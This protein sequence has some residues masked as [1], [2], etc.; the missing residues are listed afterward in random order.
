[1][2]E[3]TRFHGIHAA[4]VCPMRSDYTID[5]KA[6]TVAHHQVG[7]VLDQVCGERMAEGMDITCFWNIGFS[8]GM[9]E[10]F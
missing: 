6:Q 8:A 3:H 1:M 10:Y 2:V 4:T 7:T 9:V 5:E